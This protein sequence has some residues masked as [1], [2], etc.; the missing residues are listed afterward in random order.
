MDVPAMD[1]TW[2]LISD[3]D[4]ILLGLPLMMGNYAQ[5]GTDVFVAQIL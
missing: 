3:V 2:T 1:M 4:E 5:I